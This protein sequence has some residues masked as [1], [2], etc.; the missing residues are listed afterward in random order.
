M[1]E[2]CK[3]LTEEDKQ[4]KVN[5]GVEEILGKSTERQTRFPE[6]QQVPAAHKKHNLKAIIAF[7]MFHS[8][9]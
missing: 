6:R 2:D 1:F 3:G 8:P 9:K 5:S 4:R 7:S